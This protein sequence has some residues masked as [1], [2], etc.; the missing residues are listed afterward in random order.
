MLNR[1]IAGHHFTLLPIVPLQA[2]ADGA[3][4]RAFDF[5]FTNPSSFV[6]IQQR[7]GARPLA[8]LIN[9]RGETAQSQFGTVIFVHAGRDDLLSLGDLRGKTL[10][11]VS[12]PAFGGWQTAWLELLEHG[13]DP[14]KDLKQILFAGG[15]QPD[16]V[17][18]VRD[19]KA[20]AGVVRTDMLEGMARAGKIDLRYFRI[21]NSKQDK[22]FPFFLSTPLYPEWP[23][24]VMP[25]VPAEVEAQVREV[26]LGINPLSEAATAGHYVGW[27]PP[28]NYEPVRQLMQ[29]L[30]V[31][32]Y[33][34]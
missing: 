19:G 23:F 21:L 4:D 17:Y 3:R 22:S 6:D 13:I 8:T 5:V 34:K 14:Y 29:R 1:R 28:L 24:A 25:G 10:M 33:A 31:G 18:A 20:D 11:A 26:L 15:I 32:P 27:M 9:R 2:I 16:V 12:E 7:Y 30:Q